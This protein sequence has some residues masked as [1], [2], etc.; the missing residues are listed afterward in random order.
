MGRY[1]SFLPATATFAVALNSRSLFL[2]VIELAHD[3]GNACAA[4]VFR[5]FGD[6]LAV[7]L[8]NHPD[9]DQISGRPVD[10]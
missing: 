10:I 2:P 5:I 1:P 9:I 8:E 4:G 6:W 3:S 7:F